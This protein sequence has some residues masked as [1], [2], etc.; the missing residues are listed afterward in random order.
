MSSLTIVRVLCRNLCKSSRKLVPSIII[1]HEYGAQDI[2][3]RRSM[4]AYQCTCWTPLLCPEDRPQ[5]SGKIEVIF[6]C[7]KSHCEIDSTKSVFLSLS[8]MGS[9]LTVV[10]RKRVLRRRACLCEC[11][12][13]SHIT[14]ASH[15]DNMH[16]STDP[17]RE[18]V[19]NQYSQLL[20]LKWAEMST[21]EDRSRSQ[22][23]NRLLNGTSSDVFTF[24]EQF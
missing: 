13:I 5:Y 11:K 19:I 24:D 16:T 9:I 7:S 21:H 14:M 6:R 18:D 8:R 2:T 12:T 23:H 22:D 15:D 10:R 4:P 17:I 20:L 1:N 3:W